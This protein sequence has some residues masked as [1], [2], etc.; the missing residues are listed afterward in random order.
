M[1]MVLVLAV[2]ALLVVALIIIAVVGHGMVKRTET[3]TA[4]DASALAAAEEWRDYVAGVIDNADGR[5]PEDALDRLRSLLTTDATQLDSSAVGR[6]ARELAAANNAQVINFTVRRAGH[7]IEF[8]VQTRNLDRVNQT[9]I[10]P[11]SDATALVEL[12]GGA[13]WRGA[14][15]G[16]LYHGDCLGW[17]A[18]QDALTPEPPEPSEPPDPDE[19]E[20]EPEPEPEP[21]PVSLARLR[22]DTRL[23]G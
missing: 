17:S 6:R 7:G 3:S 1:S 5:D 21:E 22:A 4:A 16:L 20:A 14:R 10:R 9:T 11:T 23:V 2:P 15:L 12:N 8:F 13:C 18:L 19:E